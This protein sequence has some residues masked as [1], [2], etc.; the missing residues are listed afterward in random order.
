[1]K[2][3]YTK[4]N[5]D[6]N[7]QILPKSINGTPGRIHSS[8]TYITGLFFSYSLCT[9][10]C[11]TIRKTGRCQYGERELNKNQQSNS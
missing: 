8:F 3:F 10:V 9:N 11:E 5:T 2:N 1:M 7:P 4:L 6:Y